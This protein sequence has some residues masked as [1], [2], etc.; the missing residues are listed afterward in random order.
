MA[1]SVVLLVEDEAMVLLDIEGALI[2]AGF[3]VIAVTNAT[4]ALAEFDRDTSRINAVVT[5]IRLGSGTNGWEL[6]RDIRGAVPT[7]PIIY[8]SGDGALDWHAEGVP[9]SIM[10]SKPCVMVQIITALATLPNQQV[11]IARR[12]PR[13]GGR[14]AG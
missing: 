3:D 12:S 11:P 13:P 14:D 2:E 7:M 4:K 9:D 10:I 1:T 5:D 8:L 6:A